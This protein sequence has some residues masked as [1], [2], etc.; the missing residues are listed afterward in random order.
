MCG[1]GWVTNSPEQGSFCVCA[2]PITTLQNNIIPHWLSKYPE[3]SLKRHPI[4]GPQGQAMGC[5]IILLSHKHHG[6]S[7]H[8]V[9]CSR[10]FVQQLILYLALKGKLWGVSSYCC[11]ISIM[12]SQITQW[13]ALDCLFNSLFRL[14]TKRALKPHISGPWIPLTKGQ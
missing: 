7:N 4:F 11:H 13:H 8:T 9:T 5:L 2:Q 3:W 12:A 14:A 10:L 6:I 1:Q